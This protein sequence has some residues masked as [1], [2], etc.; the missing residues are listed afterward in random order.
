MELKN[1][2]AKIYM[3]CGKAR[4]GKDTLASYMSEEF[5][6]EG[7]STIILHFSSY[8]KQYAKMISNWDGSEESKP[9]ELLQVL[10]TDVIRNKIDELFFIN[11]IKQDIKVYSYF[12][13]VVIIADTRLEVEINEIRNSF[14]DVSVIHIFRPKFEEELNSKQKKHRTETGLDHFNDYDFKV[15]NDKEKEALIDEAKK[16]IKE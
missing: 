15:L 4:H 13:D 9:R 14:E 3:V 10:G 7:K 2:Q 8:I 5:K 12:F 16:I 1:K 11:R 6:N